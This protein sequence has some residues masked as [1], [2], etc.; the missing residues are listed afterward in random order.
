[1]LVALTDFGNLLSILF[2]ILIKILLIPNRFWKPVRSV[3]YYSAVITI[4][5]GFKPFALAVNSNLPDLVSD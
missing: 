2:N 5:A 3:N 4:V 1:M